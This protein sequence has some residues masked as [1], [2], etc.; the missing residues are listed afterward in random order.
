MPLNP[1]GAANGV[2]V[3]KARGGESGAVVHA[4]RRKADVGDSHGVKS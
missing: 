4:T 1:V 3:V 2:D